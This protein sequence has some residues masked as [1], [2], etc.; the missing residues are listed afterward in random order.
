MAKT[1][2][3]LARDEIHVETLDRVTVHLFYCT[4]VMAVA[5]F[6]RLFTHA[7]D[8]QAEHDVL[9]ILFKYSLYGDRGRFEVKHGLYRL[10]IWVDDEHLAVQVKTIIDV[11]VEKVKKNAKAVIDEREKKDR[12]ADRLWI[13]FFYKFEGGASPKKACKYLISLV[14]IDLTGVVDID[15]LNEDLA[16]MVIK[17]KE[18]ASTRL[19]VNGKIILPVD[20]I[21]LAEELER[22]GKEKDAI[23]DALQESNDV[24]VNETTKKD[25]ALAEAE[26]EKDEL[27]KENAELAKENAEL[28]RQLGIDD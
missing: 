8:K 5:K 22:E 16:T 7:K 27:A 21:I 15:K 10:D 26:R 2:S 14:D 17:S 24:L 11:T 13:V 18:A 6:L 23:I 25:E 20:N 4:S 12:P 9:K 19:G 28:K 1:A 3:R